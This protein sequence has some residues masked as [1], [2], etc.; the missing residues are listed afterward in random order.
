MIP[1]RVWTFCD[2]LTAETFDVCKLQIVTPQSPASELGFYRFF[3]AW[4]VSSGSLAL[5]SITGMLGAGLLGSAASTFIRQQ[6]GRSPGGPLVTDLAGIVIRGVS[7]AIVIFLAVQGGL[8]I[9]S[10]STGEPNPYV[11]L[12]TCLI[13]AVFSEDVW[14]KA[15][16]WLKKQSERDKQ[17]QT[18]PSSEK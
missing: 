9:F 16:E 13:G 11:L 15:Q 7:A 3:A 14:S 18:P 12:C 2:S 5:A 10:T 1:G 8:N 4:L 17:T 6:K